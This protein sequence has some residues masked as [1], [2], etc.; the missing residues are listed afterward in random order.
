MSEKQN[1]KVEA[2]KQVAGALA[3]DS[4]PGI[5][6]TLSV[7][8][9]HKTRSGDKIFIL[10]R[11]TLADSNNHAILCWVVCYCYIIKGY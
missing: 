9:D 8:C 7:E 11:S 2:H 4:E 5:E 6:G 3:V 1:V 10:Y